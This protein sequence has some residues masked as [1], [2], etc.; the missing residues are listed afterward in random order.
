M[1]RTFTLK[2][3]NVGSSGT[4]STGGRD[5]AL[6]LPLWGQICCCLT[7]QP[8]CATQHRISGFV[9]M[10]VGTR[11]GSVCVGWGGGRGGIL[12]RIP[13]LHYLIEFSTT[14]G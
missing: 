5:E 10:Q 9:N 12:I 13:Q 14:D 8:E 2:R 6:L 4:A 11:A 3:G 1:C 7:A